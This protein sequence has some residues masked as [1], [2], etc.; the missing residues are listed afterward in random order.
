[1]ELAASTIHEEM[2]D[3]DLDEIEFNHNA[4]SPAKRRKQSGFPMY[5]ST[6]PTSASQENPFESR[7]DGQVRIPSGVHAEQD[8]DHEDE[9]DVGDQ[10]YS[11]ATLSAP[12]HSPMI[13]SSSSI[14]RKCKT[15]TGFTGATASRAMAGDVLTSSRP[16]IRRAR[17]IGSPSSLPTNLIAPR[18]LSKLP[19]PAFTVEG[20]QY[21]VLNQRTEWK[22]KGVNIGVV[23]MNFKQQRRASLEIAQDDIIGITTESSFLDY[24]SDTEFNAL[25][26]DFPKSE[27][28]PQEL[29]ELTLLLGA[30]CTYEE[31]RD[32]VF[33]TPPNTP[34]RRFLFR[35]IDSYSRYFPNHKDVPSL[36]ERQAMFDLLCPFTRSALLVYDIESDVSEIPIVG[37]GLRKNSGKDASE[38]LSRCRLADITANDRVGIQVFLAELEYT[39]EALPRF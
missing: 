8:E 36:L 31:L 19:L 6:S 38:K 32:R 21:A 33:N 16:S 37:S 20:L 13:P 4:P 35:I 2:T 12:F 29:E 25:V 14:N 3:E 27:P 23:F 10:D 15:P 26:A 34:V 9:V 22:S 5:K 30:T 39:R 17:C 28:E 18:G 11:S 24:T 7:A 1:M